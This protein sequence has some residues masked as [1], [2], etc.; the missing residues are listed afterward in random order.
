VLNEAAATAATSRVVV[1]F[2][3]SSPF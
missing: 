2:M 3:V 1:F